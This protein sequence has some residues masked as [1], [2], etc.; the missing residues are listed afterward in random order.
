[1]VYKIVD[2]PK[3]QFNTP[4][5]D[6]NVFG[7]FIFDSTVR[8][9]LTQTSANN[10]VPKY[11]GKSAIF[12]AVSIFEIAKSPPGLNI[13]TKMRIIPTKDEKIFLLT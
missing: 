6:T 3:A 12:P 7:V 1:M 2:I 10:T 13:Y 9:T 11:N 5:G 8:M 4:N